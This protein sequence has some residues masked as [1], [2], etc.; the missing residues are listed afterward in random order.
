MTT[1]PLPLSIIAGS[2]IEQ[3]YQGKRESVEKSAF[4]CGGKMEKVGRG[5]RLKTRY[6]FSSA[7]RNVV[8]TLLGRSRFQINADLRD[9]YKAWYCSVWIMFVS[10]L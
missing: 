4:V 10:G 7:I 3:V 8:N 9:Y 2:V 6:E 5:Q 1:V